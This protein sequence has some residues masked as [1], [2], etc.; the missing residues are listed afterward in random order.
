ML[1]KSKIAST[2]VTK[3]IAVF[4][5]KAFLKKGKCIVTVRNNILDLSFCN[6]I[7]KVH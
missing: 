1:L 2:I 3:M 4:V 6:A 5:F 7:R